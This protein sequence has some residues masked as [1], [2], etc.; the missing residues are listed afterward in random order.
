MFVGFKLKKFHPLKVIT[1]PFMNLYLFSFIGPF[2]WGLN[3]IFLHI[4]PSLCF[5]HGHISHHSLHLWKT[6]LYST[7]LNFSLDN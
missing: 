3:Y 1:I 6:E 4:F 7:E 2:K 5:H